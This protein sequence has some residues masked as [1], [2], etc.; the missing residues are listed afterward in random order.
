MQY[1]KGLR[2]LFLL[3]TLFTI[4][5]VEASVIQIKPLEEKITGIE[6]KGLKYQYKVELNI[7]MTAE[8]TFSFN[9]ITDQLI[10][11]QRVFDSCKIKIEIR[12]M[13]QVMEA[14]PW[15]T[16]WETIEFE[17]GDITNWEKTFFTLTP[18][19][20]AGVLYVKSLDW[21]IDEDGIVA[22]AYSPFYL[23]RGSVN[24]DNNEQSFYRDK[25][26]GHSVL[27]NF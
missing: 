16:N 17:N 12:S 14:N 10:E 19:S 1:A 7:Y 6:T 27:G 18:K 24:G 22:A 23:E 4:Q 13:N 3:L 20:S 26:V 11:A 25:M 21:S 2:G 15:L 9:D 5:W 8:S